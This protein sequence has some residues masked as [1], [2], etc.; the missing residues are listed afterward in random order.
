MADNGP[1]PQSPN[2][3]RKFLTSFLLYP[4]SAPLDTAPIISAK[5]KD[6]GKV[7]IIAQNFHLTKFELSSSKVASD[8][9]EATECL[10]CLWPFLRL[11]RLLGMCPISRQG[12]HLLAPK[13][14]Y[15]PPWILTY[16]ALSIQCIMLCQSLKVIITEWTNGNQTDDL[17]DAGN[18]SIYFFHTFCN[19]LYM[20]WKIRDFPKF[21][22]ACKRIETLCKKYEKGD[23]GLVR[24]CLFLFIF[25]SS[26]QG[27][28]NFL[29]YYSTG[30]G[31][32]LWNLI[33][34]TTKLFSPSLAQSLLWL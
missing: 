15:S 8:E 28:G 32:G 1:V 33:Q 22:I 19:G 17:V 34:R 18:E 10:R 11:S 12:N 5:T 26:T 3:Y 13:K 23:D 6:L 25:F 9:E 30:E 7:S 21:L 4:P 24:D 31:R 29:Y 16:L 14:F 27:I 20:A 2:I